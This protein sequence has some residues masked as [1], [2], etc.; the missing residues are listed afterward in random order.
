MRADDILRITSGRGF[1]EAAMELFRMQSVRCGPYAEYL[2][3]TG[4]RPETV[5]RPEE[6][7]HMPVEIFKTHEVYCGDGPPEI[8]F[9]SSATTGSTPSRHMMRRA[10]DYEKVFTRAFSMFYGDPAAV[11]IFA[12]LPGYLERRGSS[13]VYMA[14]RLIKAG[15]GEG[16]FFLDDHDGLLE[17]MARC[18]KPKI[19]LGVSYALLDLAEKHAVRLA[20]TTVMETGGMKGKREELPRGKMHETL[21]LAFGVDAIHSEYGMAELT[22][23][24]YSR[25]GG[26]FLAPPWMRVRAADMNDPQDILPPGGR[27]LLQITDLG[28][29]SSCAFIAT[30]DVGTVDANGRFTVEGRA[31]R[32]E[33]RGCNLLVQ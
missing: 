28:N 25:G 32:S 1:D 2:E 14:D 22:S 24:A 21:A 13:L 11:A 4:C 33:I 6:I 16:G 18:C 5:K 12:L 15:G 20:G 27:G 30:R 7:P 19:L 3:L 29:I 10:E 9:T 31:G 17:A 26:V 23:Q 8:T